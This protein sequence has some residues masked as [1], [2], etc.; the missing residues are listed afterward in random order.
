MPYLITGDASY[1]VLFRDEKS[2]EVFKLIPPPT[3]SEWNYWLEMLHL[4]NLIEEESHAN[5]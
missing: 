2:G 4:E 1:Y 5:P 3:E